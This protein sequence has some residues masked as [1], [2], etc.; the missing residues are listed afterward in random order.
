AAWLL[1]SD[2]TAGLSRDVRWWGWGV[3]AALLVAACAAGLRIP[4]R[5][6]GRVLA[7][8]GDASYALYL[9]HGFAMIGLARWLKAG[10][11]RDV[12]ATM[13]L[14]A[15]AILGSV[16]LACVVH[17]WIELPLMRWLGARGAAPGCVSG[18]PRGGR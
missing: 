3:P 16:A 14:G 1:A 6:G 13:S 5:A 12:G 11:A 9:T 10:G 4:D 2:G 8:L 18:M 7:V 15:V 17:A